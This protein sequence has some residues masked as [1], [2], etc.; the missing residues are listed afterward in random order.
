MNTLQRLYYFDKVEW[1][2]KFL[3]DM[4]WKDTPPK[5]FFLRI[6]LLN[7]ALRDSSVYHGK[8]YMLELSPELMR[9]I[10][11]HVIRNS[12][13]SP[14]LSYVLLQIVFNWVWQV[15]LHP[16]SASALI[17]NSKLLCQ[18]SLIIS[19]WSLLPVLVE[20]S[21]L[22]IYFSKHMKMLPLFKNKDTKGD[23]SC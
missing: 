13:A 11:V 7:A 19:H 16:P 9:R 20:F 17:N 14:W 2:W 1:S 5:S 6:T 10:N 4:F 15:S 12:S 8:T 18:V 23:L 21:F 22:F 3:K